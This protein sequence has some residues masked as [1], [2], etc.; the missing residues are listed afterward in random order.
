MSKDL[1]RLPPE[2]I[3]VEQLQL[4]LASIATSLV[5]VVASVLV[6]VWISR[7]DANAVYIAL[8][9]MLQVAANMFSARFAMHYADTT[10]T[11]TRARRAVYT[12]ML[13]LAVE[14]VLWGSLSWLA[15]D[16]DSLGGGFLVLAIITGMAGGAASVQG[17]IPV[18]YFSFILPISVLMVARLWVLEDAV[19]RSMIFGTVLFSLMMVDLAF[20]IA[21]TTRTSIELRF[22]NEELMERLHQEKNHAEAAHEEAALANAAKSKFLAAASHDLRQP[23]HAQGLFLD[24]LSRTEL[25]PLQQELV[26]SASAA[27]NASSE[28]LDTLL[29]FSRIEAG[30]VQP[31]IQLF[32]VQTLLNKIEREFVQQADAN[33][34][35][36]RSRES[37]LSLQSDPALLELILRNLVS[38]A[39]RYT[40]S[41]GVMVTCR[42]RGNHAVLEVFDTG[43]G[44][45][46]SQQRAVFREFHQLGNPERDRAKGLG[47]GLAIVEGLARTLG[48]ALSLDSRLGRGS[49]F[50]LTVPLATEAPAAT[51]V[52]AE[53]RVT[54]PLNVRVLVVDDDISVRHS[55]QHLLRDWGCECRTVESTEDALRLVED[56]LPEV[57]ISDYRLRNQCTGVEVIETLQSAI[58]YRLPAVLIT[59]D[60]APQRLREA[61]DSGLPL[62]HKPVSPNRLYQELITVLPR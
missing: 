59:G 35:E 38:N 49:V 58:G 50:R 10:M 20:R 55:M 51:L 28:M 41:G 24:V 34:L 36:Y 42:R 21:R 8:W 48:H 45:E 13:L 40:E 3:L 61:V 46:A 6:V 29:D 7:N 39:I 11:E 54:K 9:G 44:I 1:L 4:F 52:L 15:L 18:A 33:G 25:S 2:R 27:S 31:E 62:L 32:N 12:L 57:I 14:G 5:P 47:L 37:T 56:W 19:Y 16:S 26:G 43:I 23:I 30:V 53:P 22:E 60:T 17:V